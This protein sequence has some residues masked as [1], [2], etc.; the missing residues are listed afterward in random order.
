MEY[1][2]PFMLLP[3]DLKLLGAGLP[4]IAISHTSYVISE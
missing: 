4:A 2:L 3:W 1:V